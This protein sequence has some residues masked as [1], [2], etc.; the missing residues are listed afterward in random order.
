M[1]LIEIVSSSEF[2]QRQRWSH[3]LTLVF[4]LAA[5][6]IGVNLRDTTLYA[7]T[8]YVNS[9]A[10][11]RAEYPK[12]WLKDETNG[13]GYVFRVQDTSRPGFKTTIQV[14]VRPVNTGVTQERNVLDALSLTR[15]QTLSTYNVWSTEP[16]AMPDGTVA[17]SMTYTY[18]ATQP[19]PFLETIPVV[20]QGRDILLI[21]RGQAI[22]ITFVAELKTYDEDF[23]IFERFLSS[24]EL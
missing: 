18:V 22:V 1:S 13:K 20:V 3:Y 6:L 24:L 17:T 8:T 21:R 12:N 14:A 11:I 10:G 16:F 23:A 5:F 4:A 7:T 9:Q 19:D 2:T 15:E